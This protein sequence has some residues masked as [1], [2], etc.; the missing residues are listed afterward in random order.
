MTTEI[1]IVNAQSGEQIVREMNVDELAQYAKD[2]AEAAK[3][4]VKKSEA[5]A[6]KEAANSKLEALGLTTDD[7]KALGLKVEQSTPIV[8]NEAET[9]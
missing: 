3:K 5:L 1:S 6:A 2:Q 4:A 9:I 8:I 7:L